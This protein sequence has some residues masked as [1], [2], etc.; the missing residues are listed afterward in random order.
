[1]NARHI[2]NAKQLAELKARVLQGCALLDKRRPLWYTQIDLGALDL[3]NGERCICG[4]LAKLSKACSADPWWE[5]YV[6]VLGV[7]N[8]SEKYGFI[9]PKE[10]WAWDHDLGRAAAWNYQE[11]VWRREIKARRAA[12]KQ[13]AAA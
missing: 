4:Q 5:E 11:G 12:A 9:P 8:A 1:M 7:Q 3:R 13:K 2:F 6:A 10:K